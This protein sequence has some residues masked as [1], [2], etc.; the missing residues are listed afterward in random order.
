[1]ARE[2]IWSTFQGMWLSSAVL[3]PIGIFLTYKAVTDSAL[4]NSE[5]YTRIWNSLV[6]K[7]KIWID[8]FF[9]LQ[10]KKRHA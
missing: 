9:A 3:L 1:M 5:N 2:G 7:I 6:Q 4:F 8:K 10:L